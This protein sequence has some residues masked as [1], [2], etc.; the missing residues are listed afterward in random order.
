MTVRI[1]TGATARLL[2]PEAFETIFNGGCIELRSG[3]QPAD[4]DQPATG[5]L[6]ARITTN[7][8]AW[9]AGAPAGGLGYER[10]GRFALKP[11]DAAWRITGL[12]S[13][14]VG[15]CR[16]VTAEQDDGNFSITAARIDGAVAAHESA[17]PA[18]FRIPSTTITVGQT[19]DVDGWWFTLPPM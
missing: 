11:A 8:L 12:A 7:G 13:G 6:L 2:G 17:N 3:P 14:T 16:I 5:A 4:A 1:S 10:D 18:E 9:T 19:V 15:W